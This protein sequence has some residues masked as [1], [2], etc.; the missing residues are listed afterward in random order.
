[1]RASEL[2]V[3]SYQGEVLGEALFSSMA[4]H[5]EDAEH[6]NQL[7]ALVLLERSTKQLAEPVFER[8]ALDRGDT[9]ATVK[10]ATEL[11]EAMAGISWEEFLASIEPVTEQFLLKYRE[12]VELATD[13]F[14]REI[15]ELYVAHELALAAFARRAL[16][17]ES[18]EPLELIL[19]LPHVT[20]A[21]PR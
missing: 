8:R 7:E 15:A 11:A 6:R 17:K 16:G 10:S 1:M 2:W 14:E 20:A 5:E 3:E 18:G 4:D 12:L 21:E 9:A 13:D 19:A